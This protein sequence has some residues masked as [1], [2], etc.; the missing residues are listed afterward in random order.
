MRNLCSPI[1]RST[2]LQGFHN[3]LAHVSA[4]LFE[5]NPTLMKKLVALIDSRNPRDRAGLMIENLVGNVWRSSQARHPRYAS[6]P[7]IVKTPSGNSGHFVKL[8]FGNR[9]I[10]EG[11]NA[12]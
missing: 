4:P 1:S 2:L 10:L 7:Q 8:A 6:A 11:S 5:R 12:G 9:E 3:N